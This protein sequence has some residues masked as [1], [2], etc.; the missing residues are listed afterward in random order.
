[1]NPPFVLTIAGSD[2]SAGAGIQADLKTFAANGVHGL[3]AVTAV[4]AQSPGEFD[5]L[6]AVDPALLDSQLARLVSLGPIAA[7]KTGLLATAANVEVCADFFSRRPG[8]PLVVDPVLR[9]SA[10]ATLLDK[11]GQKLL[12]ERLLGLATLITPNLPE[13]ETLL[14]KTLDTREAFESAPREIA[15]RYG[16]DT[17]VK[18]GHFLGTTQVTDAAWIDGQ[19][20]LFSRNRLEAPDLHGTGCTLSAAIAAR[21]AL[22]EDLE[23]AIRLARDYLHAAIREHHAWGESGGE[24][25][26][27]H[28]P[29]WTRIPE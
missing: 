29:N 20:L 25:A 4:T 22:G 10:G 1:M 16:C 26:L 19:T 24:A 17:L 13:A 14:G 9:A 23:S 7:A 3:T 11:N 28:F 21:L 2:P 27:N 5:A 12:Q 6:Q 18:G 15:E 8:L